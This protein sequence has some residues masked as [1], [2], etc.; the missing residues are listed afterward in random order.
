ME[1]VCIDI[2]FSKGQYGSTMLTVPIELNKYT[3][4]FGT[5]NSLRLQ[6]K[7]NPLLSI[8]PP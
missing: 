1:N 3:D 7:R 5:T 8:E 2:N 4:S 6:A